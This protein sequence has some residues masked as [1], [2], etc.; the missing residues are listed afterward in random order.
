[1]V[2]FLIFSCTV[3]IATVLYITVEKVRKHKSL[4][5]DARTMVEGAFEEWNGLSPEE[6]FLNHIKAHLPKDKG[7]IYE[8]TT[9]TYEVTDFRYLSLHRHRDGDLMV[10]VKI[11]DPIKSTTLGE[12]EFGIK[13][14][15][16]IALGWADSIKSNIDA[17]I[18]RI[19]REREVKRLSGQT[20]IIS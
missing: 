4:N 16:D 10:R 6:K 9:Y 14:Y 8:L 1:M 3:L 11:L 7:F 13:D 15:E 5:N 20:E 2:Y 18:K 12:I 19:E 17:H